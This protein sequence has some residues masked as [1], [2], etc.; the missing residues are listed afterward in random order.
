M[1]SKHKEAAVHNPIAERVPFLDADTRAEAGKLP[2]KMDDTGGVSDKK[3]VVPEAA[4]RRNWVLATAVLLLLSLF[5][6]LEGQ[7]A[8]VGFSKND[9]QAPYFHTF[10]RFVFRIMAFPLS[11]LGRYVYAKARKRDFSSMNFVR[12]CAAA[13]GPEGFGFRTFFRF[14]FLPSITVI[15]AGLFY[16]VALTYVQPS[17]TSAF[18]VSTVALSY[19]LCILFLGHPHL[20]VKTFFVLLSM[21]GVALVAYATTNDP[22]GEQAYIGVICMVGSL[23]SLSLHQLF[24]SKSFPKADS[25]QAAFSVTVMFGAGL[26]VYWPV[27]LILWLTKVE[28]WSP[29]TAPWGYLIG[30]V[31]S[32][33]AVAFLYAFCLTLSSPFFVSLGDLLSLTLSGVSDHFIRNKDLPPLQIVGSV[34]IGV[35]FIFLLLPDEKLSVD[36]QRVFRRLDLS[37]GNPEDRSARRRSL[38]TVISMDKAKPA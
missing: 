19:V 28:V 1:A 24:Y 23:L 26:L 6:V 16:I 11:L 18:L 4:A 38:P 9:F 22:M 25:D 7:L 13:A 2:R 3:N 8:A 21:S 30:S 27:P 33:L 15:G 12:H 17:V 36:L 34:I 37:S 10:L 14:Y 20:V 35:A 31:T 5:G 29:E 32:S